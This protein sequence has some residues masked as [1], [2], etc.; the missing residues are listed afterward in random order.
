[1]KTTHFPLH[2]D[3][4][5]EGQTL[6]Q[7]FAGRNLN[8]DQARQQMVELMA[9]EG[10]PYGNRTH[11]FNSRLAQELGAWA[12]TQPGGEVIHLALFQAYFVAGKN[13]ANVELLVE[14]ARDA[15]LDAEGAREALHTRAFSD[16]VDADWQRA[17]SLGVTGVPTFVAGGLGVVGA[18]PLSAL[19]ALLQQAG[20]LPLSPSDD[21]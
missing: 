3:T 21:A 15:G 6:E 19:Q 10:L 18:Q 11:T 1:M 20:A 13:L 16:V 4:P 2:P 7:L 14:T 5:D 12:D 8:L 9:A 17:M